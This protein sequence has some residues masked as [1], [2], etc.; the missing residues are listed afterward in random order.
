MDSRIPHGRIRRKEERRGEEIV[1]DLIFYFSKYS[2]P[3]F[4]RAFLTS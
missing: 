3:S 1:L 4:D 2:I